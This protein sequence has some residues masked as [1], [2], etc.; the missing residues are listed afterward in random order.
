MSSQYVDLVF[1][2]LPTGPDAEAE[3][4]EVENDQGKSINFGEWL[5][6]DDGYTVLRIRP[7]DFSGDEEGA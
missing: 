5:D 1:N 4:I 6:R 7:E 3:F 2:A